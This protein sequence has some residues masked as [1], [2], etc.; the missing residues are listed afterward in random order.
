MNLRDARRRRGQD[1][2]IDITPLI[3]VVFILLIFFL[4][5]SAVSQQAAGERETAIPIDLPEASSGDQEIQGD[6]LTLTVTEDGRIEIEGG[7]ELEGESLDEKLTNLYK[8]DP[9]AQ[10][11]MRGDKGANY[12]RII[13][14]LDGVKQIGFKRVD[15]IITNP[16]PK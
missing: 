5:T 7:G 2:T 6:P 12:G 15:L 16:N 11:L 9:D 8:K 13:E 1:S 10:I 4:L 3:D 14:L